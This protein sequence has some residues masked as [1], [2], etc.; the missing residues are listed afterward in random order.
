MKKFFWKTIVWCRMEVKITKFEKYI[1]L[2]GVKIKFGMKNVNW[3]IKYYFFSKIEYILQRNKMFKDVQTNP[4]MKVI[5]I[6]N[7]CLKFKKTLVETMTKLK[8]VSIN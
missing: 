7:N 4:D 8:E 6:L 3:N 5:T 1:N 2:K